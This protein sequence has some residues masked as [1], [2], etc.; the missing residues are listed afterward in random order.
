MAAADFKRS[1]RGTAGDVRRAAGIHRLGDAERTR[2]RTHPRGAG[3]A[4]L[5]AGSPR[6]RADATA[7]I[8]RHARDRESRRP[9]TGSLAVAVVAGDHVERRRSA[10]SR[11]RRVD[12]LS[13]QPGR[14][15]STVRGTRPHLRRAA[16]AGRQGRTAA[17][18]SDGDT[19]ARTHRVRHPRS[20]LR[21]RRRAA[22]RVRSGARRRGR[23]D[24]GAP[25]WIR[26]RR[27][28]QRRPHLQRDP[29]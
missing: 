4:A 13:V 16:R 25:R 5:D 21:Q 26:D 7:R 12:R 10:Q 28:H 23:G 19:A 3:A 24:L 22:E 14:R 17:V 15:G 8:R 11:C 9:R 27:T 2:G 18:V 6:L 29:G 1:A 20:Q